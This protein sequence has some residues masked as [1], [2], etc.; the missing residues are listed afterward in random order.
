MT[1]TS[2]TSNP[3][4]P[5][6]Y[7]SLRGDDL[8]FTTRGRVLVAA[9]LAVIFVNISSDFFHKDNPE[10]VCS[11]SAASECAAC[12]LEATVATPY[13]DP[14]PLP[15]VP[16]VK[17]THFPLREAHPFVPSQLPPSGRAPPSC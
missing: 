12:Q 10:T 16:V 11:Y 17:I 9:L 4:K 13:C 7:E 6:P 1:K 3:I 5:V 8:G 14:A 15:P 2:Y